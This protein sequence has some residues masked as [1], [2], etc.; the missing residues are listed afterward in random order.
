MDA[1]PRYCQDAVAMKRAIG[2]FLEAG[3][4]EEIEAIC[5][6]GLMHDPQSSRALGGMFQ[7]A[8]NKNGAGSQA[9]DWLRR[10]LMN[11]ALGPH[12]AMRAFYAT[13]DPGAIV[14]VIEG[15]LPRAASANDHWLARMAINLAAQC[16]KVPSEELLR[17][18]G[19]PAFDRALGDHAQLYVRENLMIFRHASGSVDMR[20]DIP[21]KP[22]LAQ[23]GATTEEQS[24][25][26]I[27]VP[28]GNRLEDLKSMVDS[29]L[30]Q[31]SNQLQIVFSVLAD[32]QGT[33]AFLDRTVN[34]DPRCLIVEEK[35]ELFSKVRAIENGIRAAHGDLIL[36]LD[37]DCALVRS[38]TY[39]QIQRLLLICPAD[40]YS[41]DYRGMI[42]LRRSE[43]TDANRLRDKIVAGQARLDRRIDRLGIG[44]DDI[45]WICEH[46][47]NRRS[48]YALVTASRTERVSLSRDG[49]LTLSVESATRDIPRLINHL[50]EHRITAR[51]NIH[52]RGNVLN[53]KDD[54]ISDISDITGSFGFEP[55]ITQIRRYVS[56]RLAATE[57]EI[58]K[59]IS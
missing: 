58:S 43:F 52:A 41:I 25:L 50:G 16:K 34:M 7:V 36:M 39:E 6:L 56:R 35:A 51:R 59:A 23:S 37:C 47:T 32:N 19:I 8:I 10:L 46:I 57:S 5:R 18:V 24:T 9:E 13:V 3:R 27:V 22:A 33:R 53:T 45:V 44:S 38:D 29:V 42:L 40:I 15:I 11:R 28:M 30:A 2:F 55:Y 14:T 21:R 1:A 12:R 48:R 54:I 31:T 20:V 4:A 17:R 26:S 49:H